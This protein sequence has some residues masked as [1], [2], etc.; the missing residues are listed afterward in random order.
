MRGGF[1]YIR[2]LDSLNGVKV[3]DVTVTQKRVSPNDKIS[4]AKHVFRIN[5]APS[6]LGAV[7][8]PPPDE[9]V[10]DIMKQS[11]LQ[12][13]GLEKKHRARLR[14]ESRRYD[15]TDDSAGQLKQRSES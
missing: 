3:N 1:W 4:I 14:Q 2:D 11:L 7:G 5:Y 13:A 12:R 6:D 10:E 8:P 15:V 9:P